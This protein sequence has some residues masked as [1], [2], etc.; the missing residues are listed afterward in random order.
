MTC[1]HR[2]PRNDNNDL[3][4]CTERLTLPAADNT[5]KGQHGKQEHQKTTSL[6]RSRLRTETR[7]RATH[8]IRTSGRQQAPQEPQTVPRTREQTMSRTLEQAR[9]RRMRRLHVRLEQAH[10]AARHWPSTRA[11]DLICQIERQIR[12]LNKPVVTTNT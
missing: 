12:Q 7:T 1:A 2:T 4:T 3:N 8:R 5:Q 11:Q 10:Q 6:R 9:E